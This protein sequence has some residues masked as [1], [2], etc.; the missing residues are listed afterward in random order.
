VSAE[1][2]EEL[3][4]A[5]HPEWYGLSWAGASAVDLLLDDAQG[6]AERVA[7]SARAELERLEKHYAPMLALWSEC[8][9]TDD[10]D[11]TGRG[12]IST[13]L[14]AYSD[15][16]SAYLEWS[17]EVLASGETS[18]RGFSSRKGICLEHSD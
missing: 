12:D 18:L 13:A 11:A 14:R 15:E 2:N 3:Y 16:A 9:P 7:H 4:W 1:Q 10:E 5:E 6:W 17:E 8:P